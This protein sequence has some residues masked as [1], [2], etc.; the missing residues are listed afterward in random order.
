MSISN[1]T[2]RQFIGIAAAGIASSTGARAEMPK[3]KNPAAAEASKAA[4]KEVAP[5]V[6]HIRFGQPETAPLRFRT[7]AVR[8]EGFQLLPPIQTLPLPQETIA[9]R[10]TGRGC[11]L[12][13]PMTSDERIFGF[14]LNTQVYDK[15]DRRV[16]LRP[17]D[18]TEGDLGDSHA[19]VP[20]Y[21]STAGYGIYVDTLRY[22]SFYT[23]NVA[24]ALVQGATGADGHQADNTQA[25]Y[26]QH[27][28]STK[29]MLVDIPSAQG[30]DVYI[31]GGPSLKEAVCR[32]NL[33]SGGGA[34]PPLWGLGVA[35]RGKGDF[36]ASD[37]IHLAQ[38]LRDQKMPCDIWG[39]EPGWQTKTYSCS[40][41]WNNAKFPDPEGFIQQ[42]H[43]LG[44]RTSFWQHAFT[45]GSS[46]IHDALKPL[47]G[48]YKV[49]DG[50]VPDFAT[51]G[52][53]KVFGSHQDTVLFAKGA[54]SVKLDECDNQPDSA[55]PWSF[56]EA[57]AFPS[58]LD[59]ER[60]HSL[61]GAAYQ[62]TL[63]EPLRRRNRRTW[64][65]ARNAHALAAPLPYVVYSDS[66]DHRCYVR[67]L[68]NAGFCGLL[69]TPEVRDAGSAEELCRRVGTVIFSPYAMV[70]AWYIKLPPWIQVNRDKNNAGEP[71][72]EQ[73]ATT[74]AVRSLFHLRMS[75]LP[76]LYSAF[77]DY[78]QMGMPPT[79]G[80]VMDWPDDAEARKVDDQFMYGRSL[81]VAP[82]FAGQTARD[83]YLPTGLWHD[84]WTGEKLTGG[85]RLKGVSK[86]L[87]QVP[88]YVRDNSLLPLAAPIESVKSDTEFALTVRVYGDNPAPFILYADDGETYNYE[89]GAQSR[90][91]LTWN[92]G[93]GDTA[94]S[95]G[96][97]GPKRYRVTEWKRS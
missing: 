69:W 56:P 80:L 40:F 12:T 11:A 79:R 74:E 5:G 53:R 19:P 44:Y 23:G 81:L 20:F 78:A 71:M 3:N 68:A 55:S 85:R 14:G 59:G 31:F 39:V 34:L 87:D 1:L 36:T 57:A 32:Y 43:T 96:F 48:D 18:Q 33:F 21:V 17:S 37:S 63:L 90:I 73:A 75:L 65:L 16:F 76:Y 51:Q 38:S 95:G 93:Q 54:D 52:A 45:H 84:F 94:E 60:Y 27:I 89:R 15:T 7:A 22:A 42:M 67:G 77:N 26:Q 9:F 49:W 88:L 24:P 47:S 86:P 64:G 2:R 50:L 97:T 82:L 83:V 91:A 13:L 62:Q 46:P 30:V 61:F 4:A 72:P 28:L 41:V 35:Y 6:W 29:T 66:Y 70:N 10:M 25:L 8:T 58:G 92:K